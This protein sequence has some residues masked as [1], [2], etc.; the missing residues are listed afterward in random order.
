[1]IGDGLLTDMLA[2]ERAGVAKLLV[3]TGVARKEDIPGAP[4]A[5]DAVY[6][7]LPALQ[8]ALSA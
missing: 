8:K 4:A 1:M 7:D 3:L 5:P 2:G 6:E